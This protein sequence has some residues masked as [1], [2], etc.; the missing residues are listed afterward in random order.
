MNA[1]LDFDHFTLTKDQLAAQQAFHNFLLDPTETVFVLSGYSGC[2]KSTLVRKLIDDI[3]AI[4]R[5]LKLINPTG[6][7]YEIQL[8]ATTNKAAENLAAITGMDVSTIQS[9]LGLL[10]RTDYKTSVTELTPKKNYT[11]LERNILFIDE[12]SLVDKDLLGW[13][14]KRTTDCKIVFVGDPAQLTPVKSTGTPV[15]DAGFTGAELTEVVRQPKKEGGLA[16]LH[17][18]TAWAAD[19]RKAV[20]TGEWTP[21][22]PDGFHI[23]RLTRDAFNRAIEEEFTRQ[24]WKY[25]DSKILAWTNACVIAFNQRVRSLAKGDPH[26]QEADY[27]VVNSFMQVGKNSLKTDQLVQITRIEPDTEH[28]DVAGNWVTVDHVVRAFQPKSLAEKNDAIRKA[29][30]A[31]RL[32]DVREME[33]QWF[34]LRGAYAQTIN[35]SQGSTYDKVFIDLDDI[36]RCHSWEQKARMLYVGPSRARHHVYLCGDLA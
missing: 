11:N 7:H 6:K 18:I 4:Q 14:F 2:G 20:I 33:D 34:D 30:N 1:I 3:P 10:V 27:A 28:L 31:N 36:K 22:K 9:T 26:F 8:T 12:A 32:M 35:K 17:P 5:T 19:M 25:K 16:E 15:F 13:I 29:R 24:D 23:Q 21:F